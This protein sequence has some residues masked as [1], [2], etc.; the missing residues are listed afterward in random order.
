MHTILYTHR[1]QEYLLPNLVILSHFV[2]KQVINDAMKGKLIEEDKVEC[3]PEQ[4]P[5][6]VLDE[7]VDVCLVRRYF[8]SDAWMLL[9][10]EQS[11]ED[12]M[13]VQSLSS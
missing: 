9:T 12:G 5:D 11:K 10:K 6:S 8:S 4:I 2:D 7:N 1:P 3:R 13:D